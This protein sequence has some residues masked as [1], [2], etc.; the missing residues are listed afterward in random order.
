MVL[1]KLMAV[2]SWAWCALRISLRLGRQLPLLITLY[3]YSHATQKR[4]IGTEEAR[5][6]RAAGMQ[7]MA[8]GIPDD[9]I[10]FGVLP[11][12]YFYHFFT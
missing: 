11:L 2:P 8:V 7:D 9:K 3:R 1:S 12:S 5:K 10:L 4:Y 6:K